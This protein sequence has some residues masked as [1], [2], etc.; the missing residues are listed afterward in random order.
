M[1]GT[2]RFENRSNCAL[3]WLKK[4]APDEFKFSVNSTAISLDLNDAQKLF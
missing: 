4:Y 2:K 3:N 1:I